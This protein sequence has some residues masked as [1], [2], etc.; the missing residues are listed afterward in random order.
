M[1]NEN[2]SGQSGN[3]NWLDEILATPEVGEE[4]GPDEHA[5]RSANLTHPS[6]AEVD[7][8]IQET[9]S[10]T[11]DPASEEAAP[12]QP[13]APESDLFRDE[14]YRDAFGEG[15]EL[16]QVFSGKPVKKKK[17]P[18]AE[19]AAPA[20]K[21]RPKRKK[22]AGLLAIPHLLS[23]VIWVVI[24]LAIGVSLGRM[25]WVCAADVLGFGREEE[26]V[27]ITITEEDIADIDALAEKLKD[28]GLIRYP[29]LF[30]LYASFAIDEGDISAGTFE[31]NTVY[32][33]RA[34]VNYLNPSRARQEVELMFQEGFTCADI[35]AKLEE[36]NVCT[37]AELEECAANGD[38]GDY[39]FLESV[40]RGS[41][42]CL[43]GYLFPDTYRFYVDDEPDR[44]LR[45]FLNN[46]DNRFSSNHLEEKLAPLN[47]RLA[48]VLSS[49]GYNQDYID[50][51][52]MTIHDIVIVASMIEKEKATDLEGYTVGSVIYNRLTNPANY[53]YLNIDATL[54]Y[55]LGGNIDPETGKTKP[56]TLEDTK[57]D[58]PYNTYNRTG[59]IPGPIANPGLSSL[60]AALEPEDTD[61]YFY[62]LDPDAG[63][64]KFFTN[65]RDHEDFLATVS[66]D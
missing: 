16:E 2:R 38:L 44:V 56:L 7:Q 12:A 55:A 43:E 24:I 30:K 52:M 61:Y 17:K 51:H 26:L 23:T 39:W 60:D 1:D 15:E 62:A 47:E 53:P 54:I 9:L 6:D 32:D 25:I 19:Q 35:F 34:L 3:E 21:G 14:E 13:A 10:G 57:I 64:H 66:Y 40:E 37:V 11:W 31:L 27:T 36:N 63:T 59:L 49:R 29:S 42:Y 20:P 41:K 18:A 33:Y 58:S 28:A 22:G 65:S 5:I 45:K 48:Q 4:I 50:E 8:I 46:F